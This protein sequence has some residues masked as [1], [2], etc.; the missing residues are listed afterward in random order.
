M[1]CTIDGPDENKSGTESTFCL[2]NELEFLQLFSMLGAG[3]DQVDSGRREARV[4]EDV[5]EFDDVVGLV[6]EGL[7]EEVAEIVGEDFPRFDAGLF[8]EDFH[9][10]PNLFPIDGF[11]ASGEENLAGSDFLFPGVF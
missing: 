9:L 2:T 3:R 10:G 4:A 8:A 1:I 11:A 5:G 7:G 6:V